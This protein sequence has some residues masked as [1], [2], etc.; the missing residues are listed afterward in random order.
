MWKTFVDV[1]GKTVE[2]IGNKVDVIFTFV[3]MSGASEDARCAQVCVMFK[4]VV[5]TFTQRDG[6]SPRRDGMLTKEEAR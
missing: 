3:E 6:M 2:V 5:A 1:A 4:D